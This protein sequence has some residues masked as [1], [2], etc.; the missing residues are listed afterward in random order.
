V[1]PA[2]RVTWT[3][4]DDSRLLEN[5]SD[6]CL[7]YTWERQASAVWMTETMHNSGDA[8]Y[9]G[10]FRKRVARANLETLV[11]PRTPKI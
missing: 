7:T 10:E 8:S 1:A 4:P 2:N 11:Q 9:E 5:Y 6:T 3:P